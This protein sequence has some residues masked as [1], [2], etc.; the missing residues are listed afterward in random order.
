MRKKGEEMGVGA[1]ADLVR[2]ADTALAREFTCKAVVDAIHAGSR[3]FEAVASC[4]A[5][6]CCL[7]GGVE[8]FDPTAARRGNFTAVGQVRYA[9]CEGARD[10]TSRYGPLSQW[11]THDQAQHHRTCKL[12]GRRASHVDLFQ[13]KTNDCTLLVRK[14][15]LS[16]ANADC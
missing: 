9:W 6:G 11:C 13:D 4:L 2:D 15:V 7:G 3:T 16:S 5:V 14:V 10:L 12:E 8:G 1:G